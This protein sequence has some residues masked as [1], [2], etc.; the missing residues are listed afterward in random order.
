MRT[1]IKLVL[2]VAAIAAGTT[3]G[4]AQTTIGADIAPVEGAILDL[5]QQEPTSA[6]V[7]ATKG[8][9][10]PRVQLNNNGKGNVQP[11][12]NN[13][14]ANRRNYVGAIVHNTRE[15]SSTPTTVGLTSG[16]YIWT[17]TEWKL[18]GNEGGL[19]YFYMPPFNIELGSTNQT[20][21]LY[22]E[23]Y[24][25]FTAAGNASFKSSTGTAIPGVY[26]R[27]DLYYVVLDHSADVNVVSIDNT[28]STTAGTMTCRSNGSA[29]TDG[30]YINIIC[31]IKE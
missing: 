29:A 1:Q 6:N 27:H 5:K 14:A 12:G 26:T 30:S 28:S 31:V 8:M 2:L 4:M 15:F 9:V 16:L 7:T 21:D 19:P 23:Y 18:I 13:N 20:V 25:R 17:G 3:A 24:D 10:L 11:L 22:Q